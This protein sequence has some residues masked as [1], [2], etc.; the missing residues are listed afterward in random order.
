[1]PFRDI[2]WSKREKIVARQA[3]DTAYRR[4]CTAITERLREMAAN[5]SEPAD[6]WALHNHLTK[7]RDEV[8]YKYDYRYSVLPRVFARLMCDGWLFEEDLAGLSDEKLEV[9][10]RLF[11]LKRELEQDV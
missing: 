4:E 6:I 9:I 5:I 7:Q 3:F 10:H 8:D 11:A 2:S 1:M